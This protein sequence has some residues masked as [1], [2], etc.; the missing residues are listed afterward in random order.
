MPAAQESE[1]GKSGT[2]AIVFDS[3]DVQPV[4]GKIVRSS[5]GE[6]MGRL[7]DV[8]VD[9]DGQPRAAII[10]F[11]GFLGVGS[12]KIA[13]DWGALDFSREADKSVI[14][15]Q[16]TRDQVKTAPEFKEGAPVVV[17]GASAGPQAV[18]APTPQQGEQKSPQQ[19]VQKSP[20][21]GEQK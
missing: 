7:V 2:L 8:V 4:L 5:T 10:D 16:L 17:L 20:Q 19:G 3:R 6:D 18:P 1:L 14:R 11:G 9:H 21:Q 13:V 12:R 15:V